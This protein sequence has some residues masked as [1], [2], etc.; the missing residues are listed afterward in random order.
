MIV[1]LGKSLD[2]Q[3]SHRAR[4]DLYFHLGQKFYF[5]LFVRRVP[6]CMSR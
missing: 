5:P 6:L 2:F 3:Q 1:S 4:L